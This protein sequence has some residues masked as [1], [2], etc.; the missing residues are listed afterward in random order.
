MKLSHLMRI[1]STTNN[2]RTTPKAVPDNEGE[3]LKSTKSKL[4]K[5]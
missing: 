5:N 1:K 2:T 3:R 4:Q